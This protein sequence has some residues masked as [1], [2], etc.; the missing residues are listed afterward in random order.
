MYEAIEF[1]EKVTGADAT[2]GVLGQS[3]TVDGAIAVAKKA[4]RQF[5]ASGVDLYAWWLVR[6]TGATV[7]RWIADN[8]SGKEFV[9]DIRS[10]E[11]LEVRI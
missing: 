6:E 8:H 2:E 1:V 9:L 5:E 10:G 11:L 3:D 7:A 4:W